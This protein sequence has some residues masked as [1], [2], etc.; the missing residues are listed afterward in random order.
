MEN[1][2]GEFRACRPG[3]IPVCSIGNEMLACSSTR[4]VMLPL[5]TSNSRPE[6]VAKKPPLHHVREKQGW[7]GV[8]AGLAAALRLMARG[9]EG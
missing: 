1:S 5:A 6:S 4:P 8:I 7:F 2:P 3:A 9:G